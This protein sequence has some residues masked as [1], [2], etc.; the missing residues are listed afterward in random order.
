MS[1]TW[2]VL[3]IF[4][5]LLPAAVVFLARACVG[6]EPHVA[7]LDLATTVSLDLLS[8]VLLSKLVTLELA[9]LGSRAAWLCAAGPVVYRRR[10]ELRTWARSVR[11]RACLV[12][13]CVVALLVMLSVHISTLCG[14]WDRYWHIPLTSS[15]RGQHAP[16]FNVY[17]RADRPLYYH[18]A[19]NVAGAM[20]QSL[21][22]DHLHTSAALC[23]AHDV[24]FGLFGLVL[25]GVAPSFGARRLSLMLTVG[26]GMVLA[27]PVT[28]LSEGLTR[29]ELGRAT[30]PLFS[31]SFRP[32]VS[33]AFVL[34]LG[35]VGALLIP[36]LSD[37]RT[38]ARS[39]RP[40]LISCTALLVLS[41]ETSLALLG[42]LFAVV[43]FLSPT[44]LG[45]SRREGALVGILLLGAIL[46]TVLVF[47]GSFS[48]GSP[49]Q[50]LLLV[51]PRV[52]GFMQTAVPLEGATGWWVFI[53]EFWGVLLALLS[54]CICTVLTRRRAVAVLFIGYAALAALGIGALTVL[55]IN[56][57]GTECHRF[58]TL[59]MLL[60]PL[61]TLFFATRP[62]LASSFEQ[63]A[64]VKVPTALALT[65]PAFSSLEWVYGLGSSICAR[66]GMA[67]YAE[68]DCRAQMGAR[69]GQ[70]PVIAYVEP[71]FW[72]E[73][74]G[75]RPLN[76]PSP[77]TGGG[78]DVSVG[79]PEHGWGAVTKLQTWQ[80]DEP[81]VAY[82]L[83]ENPD[84]VCRQA[85]ADANSCV[86]ENERVQRCRLK[87][88]QRP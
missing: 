72:Y 60:A 34:I 11:W 23:R 28:L 38:S 4:L 78:N 43:W 81:I 74:A 15:L 70:K 46:G 52:P 49:R 13:V 37:G 31:L 69:F 29:P 61:C 85:L 83:R 58:A 45:E 9:T 18:Y 86:A 56:G 42:L 54:G 33:L 10:V 55:E 32:H 35:F 65:L 5:Y 73:F 71:S 64:L 22:F 50:H 30:I 44:A 77:N 51:A 48:P 36:L 41:D 6:R 24:F 12:P 40:C 62:E 79:W 84:T 76:A 21:S 39:T 53:L 19:G 57:G 25:T 75:C 17:E 66:Y 87:V 3:S 88:P 2:V 80:G 8:V 82:C 63:G 1:A 26:L 68:T 67:I 7:A 47:G 59:P 16:F 14:I 20:L 27:G